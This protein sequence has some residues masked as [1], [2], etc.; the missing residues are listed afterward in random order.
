MEVDA[1]VRVARALVAEREQ[2]LAEPADGDVLYDRSPIDAYAHAILSMETGGD[3]VPGFL[4]EMLPLVVRSLQACDCL[5]L[6]P[7]EDHVVDEDD[8]FR[9]LDGQG[10][11]RFESIM[12]DLL[13][14]PCGPAARAG[15]AV[16]RVRGDRRC[17]VDQVR[18][19][20]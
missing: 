5:V 14:S 12:V 1:R 13:E 11:M 4:A 20:T 7:I 9:Y 2:V 6:V 3:V 15:V 8:G 19:L 18:R 17:R 16:A 10:R